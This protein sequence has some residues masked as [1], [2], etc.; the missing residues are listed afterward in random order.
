M[1]FNG[2]AGIP[3]SEARFSILQVLLA[4]APHDIAAEDLRSVA[5]KAHG[6]VGADLSAVVREAGTL[7]IKRWLASAPADSSQSSPRLTL[8]D[9]LAALPSVRPS[10]LRSLFLDTVPVRY[11]DIGGQAETIQKLRECVEWPLLHPE[12]FA[13]LGV[14]APRGVLLY[15]PPGCSKTLLV[16]ACATESG[17]NFLA[18]KGP[19]VSRILSFVNRSDWF[20]CAVAEQVCRRV[21]T[22]CSRDIQQ[23]SRCCAFYRIFRMCHEDPCLDSALILKLGRN[24]RASYLKDGD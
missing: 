21:R 11:S 20:S 12:A 5:A 2:S 13:R 19:E 4:K 24:R 1:T 10:A 22:S 9:L 14:R 7:A 15:G 6:Y 3:N 18:V 16:R 17:V 8:A 23:G